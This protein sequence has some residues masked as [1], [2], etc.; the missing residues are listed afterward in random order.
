MDG[1][2]IYQNWE[3]QLKKLKDDFEKELA[4]VRAA[5]NAIFEQK[6]DKQQKL[7]GKYIQDDERII[8]SAPEI[9]I[10]NVNMGGVLNP[11]GHGNLIIRGNNICMEGVGNK[12]KLAMRAPIISQT[13]EDPGI[14][15]EEHVVT[16]T[17]QIISQA[18]EVTIESNDVPD[19]G[20]FLK[21]GST[22]AGSVSIRADKEISIDAVKSKKTLSDKAKSEIT[23]WSSDDGKK[24]FKDEAEAEFKKFEKA[25]KEIDDLLKKRDSLMKK[26]S[27]DDNAIRTDYRDVDELNIRIDELSLELARGL[28]ICSRKYAQLAEGE[29]R[30]K[31]YK[32]L[33][34]KLNDISEDNFKKNKTG[35]SV[36][37]NSEQINLS[38]TDGDGNNRTNAE[39]GLNVTANSVRFEGVYT[40]EGDL[41]ETN[42]L[43]VNM[44][45]VSITSETKKNPQY[46][47]EKL[48]S[49]DCDTV[50]N[51]V[52]RS[53]DVLIESVDYK[54]D[55]Q[56]Y[57]EKGLTENGQ[58]MLRSN[59]IGLSTVKTSDVK[60]G[61]DGKITD[62][63]YTSDGKI[64][65]NTKNVSVK[66]IDSKIE[67]GNYKETGLTKESIFSIQAENLA[68]SATDQEGKAT[69][70][71]SI[72]AKEV[73]VRSVDVD[74]QSQDVKQVADGG[75]VEILGQEALLYGADKVATYSE[76]QAFVI[77]QEEASLHSSKLAEVT[78][79]GNVVR[80]EGGK[81][82][83]SGSKNTLFG[84]TSVNVLKSPSITVDN[85]TVGSALK[86][87]NITDGVMVD[88]K[89]T[90]TSSA[91]SKAEEAKK[92][93]EGAADKA[94]ATDKADREIAASMLA[95][96]WKRRGEDDLEDN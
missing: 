27:D 38:S 9:I 58:I 64:F 94:A 86:A 39:A 15:G 82:D 37:I 74:P 31:Y 73:S 13:A 69:G 83:I 70:S 7:P 41:E 93:E 10:G 2:E 14:D 33:Q 78:Q 4:E 72:N 22:Q 79:D 28:Y 55:K 96:L 12:G 53:K 89:D 6:S 11:D 77:G 75:K 36:S 42:K 16:T 54:I 71:A 57:K 3:D 88:A 5:K 46:E 92:P 18:R 76:K 59:T 87:P 30:N 81:V 40:Q 49:M 84:E 43:A 19:G 29:R 63:T 34:Q 20:A 23:A 85:L 65:L 51:V 32:N 17:S 60:V 35:T 80:L 91:K 61:D 47:N 52:I 25:R 21:P 66:S 90:S 95:D 50:G 67:G 26:G 1:N 68:F 44:R 8:I 45:N 24:K 62:A 48:T 56:K